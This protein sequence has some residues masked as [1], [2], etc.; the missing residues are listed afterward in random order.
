MRKL[1]LLLAA[2]PL[3]LG[4]VGCS[5]LGISTETSTVPE[6]SRAKEV[7]P[8]YAAAAAEVASAIAQ[9]QP[10]NPG[11]M[12]SV[13]VRELVIPV[14]KEA[15]SKVAKRTVAAAVSKID[16]K[17]KS[18]AVMVKKPTTIRAKLTP[19][20]NPV[21]VSKDTAALQ[22]KAARAVTHSSKPKAD[23]RASTVPQAMLKLVEMVRATASAMWIDFKLYS[24]FMAQIEQETCI[25]AT[26]ARCGSTK[27]ELKTDR[28]Y[29]FG[30]GQFTVAYNKDG[31]ERF[32]AWQELRDKDPT[33]KARWTWENR[34]DA[35]LQ[36]RSL[37][38]K[39][40]MNWC[41]LRFDIANDY[42]RLA[43][44]AVTYNSG[45]VL[46][47]R[48]L[49][50]SHADCDPSKWFSTATRKGVE[51]YSVK[52]DVKQKGYGQS[53]RDISRE[54]PRLVMLRRTKYIPIVDR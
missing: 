14:V 22:P 44:T 21:A 32:N 13:I 6:I 35:E 17:K 36:V 48:R 11:S 49:C 16:Q 30:I 29:G 26:S 18:A 1:G 8:S 34:Y 31:T 25:S 12:A 54:Y 19:P 38:I 5:T 33:L 47:D 27:A 37:V 40:K 45:S 42:E 10:Q 51:A 4:L 28:E 3:I 2:M 46:T 43:F 50:M 20:P 41:S 53:F 9:Q 39:N 7:I 52:S 15:A 24:F 23:W